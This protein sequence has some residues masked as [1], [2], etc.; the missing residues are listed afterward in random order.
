M[1]ARK[2]PHRA[3]RAVLAVLAA[4]VGALVLHPGAGASPA[5]RTVTVPM[6]EYYYRPATA[7]IRV[8]DR[9]R[10]VNRGRIGHTVADVDARGSIRGRVIRPRLLATGGSQVV[11]FRRPGTV[12][13]VCTLHPTRMKGT[14]VVRRY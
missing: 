8:G 7:T 4:G 10:F 3:L 5:S 11:L 14:I 6:G 13:Y 2:A 12:R 1:T 9:V